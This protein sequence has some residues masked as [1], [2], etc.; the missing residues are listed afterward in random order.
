MPKAKMLSE[1][2]AEDILSMITVDKR[3]RPGDKLPNEN[4]LSEE[5]QV[6]RTTLREA[7]RIL[8]TGNILEIK[9]GKGTF[10]TQQAGTAAYSDLNELS[11]LKINMRDLFEIRLMF[12]PEN[13]YLAAQRATKKEMNAIL[14]HGRRIEEMIRNGEDRT[15]EEQAFHKAIAKATHNG[16]MNELIPIILKAIEGGVKLLQKNN[17]LSQ[18]NME[19]DRMLME[20]LEQRN[21]EGARTAMKIHILHALQELDEAEG[22]QTSGR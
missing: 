12:E 7:I 17:S 9:R 18:K 19:D 20:F 3:F 5:L 10:V 21:P 11:A 8:V 13:A 22:T 4:E 14:E 15:L 6:S 2:V 16:F 1:T